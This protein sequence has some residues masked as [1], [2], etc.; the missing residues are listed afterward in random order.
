M[1]DVDANGA[2]T[3]VLANGGS[4]GPAALGYAGERSAT[5]LTPSRRI[6]DGRASSSS[7]CAFP[8][9]AFLDTLSRRPISAVEC[10]WVQRSLK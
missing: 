4:V 6:G 2:A 10:P 3:F 1:F 8:T 7:R 5:V 9:M